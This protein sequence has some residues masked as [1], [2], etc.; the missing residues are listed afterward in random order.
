MFMLKLKLKTRAKMSIRT[1][2]ALVAD[3]AL[4]ADLTGEHVAEF[5]KIALTFMQKGATRALFKRA[6]KQ[7]GTTDAKVESCITGLSQIF[8]ECSKVRASASDVMISTSDFGFSADKQQAVADFYVAHKDEI[9]RAVEAARPVTAVPRL[10][11]LHWRLDVEV[12]RRSI[13]NCVQ[14]RQ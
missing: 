10:V 14:V 9:K 7:I 13:H 3:V 11:D 8:T 4:L 12:A 6:A 2:A 5:C 1:D